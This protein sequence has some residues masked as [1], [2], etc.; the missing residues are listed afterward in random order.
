MTSDRNSKS[1]V[2][3][4]KKFEW[5]VFDI[6]NVLIKL[7]RPYRPKIFELAK[8]EELSQLEMLL[9][10]NFVEGKS[11]YSF[12]ERYQ[13]GHY[14]TEEYLDRLHRAI[15]GRM[16]HEEI[17][18]DKNDL[19]V[20]EDSETADILYELSDTQAL[21]CFSNTHELHWSYINQKFSS[22][23]IFQIQCTSFEM[24]VAKPERKAFQALCAR[25]ATTPQHILFIDDRVDNVAG[26]KKAGIDSLLFTDAAALR[27][28]LATLGLIK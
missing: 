4:H 2:S 13:L 22:M 3:K 19:L 15:G 23:A 20:G 9:Q 25:L 1:Q 27:A 26:A 28:D 7:A 5:V 8:P 12:N 18:Q 21:A 11:E 14:S 6:G 16:S 17:R 10:D 24:G